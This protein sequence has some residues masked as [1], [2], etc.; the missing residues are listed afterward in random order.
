MYKGN[1]PGTE[2]R[3]FMTQPLLGKYVLYKITNLCM[4]WEPRSNIFTGYL[5]ISAGSQLRLR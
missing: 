4:K 1:S 3:P 2:L 5:L